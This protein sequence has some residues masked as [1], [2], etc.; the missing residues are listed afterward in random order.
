MNANGTRTLYNV[1]LL[2]GH[3]AQP[4]QIYQG[5]LGEQKEGKYT[6]TRGEAIKKARMFGGKIRPEENTFNT[7]V[8]SIE[9]VV[10]ASK[11]IH[12]KVCAGIN[13]FM[14][15]LCHKFT[16]R[17]LEEHFNLTRKDV[18]LLLKNSGENGTA[19]AQ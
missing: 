9:R 4:D 11:H 2:A 18:N 13:G 19:E 16:L 7:K 14:A 1:L 12:Y 17:E 8:H 5:F 3:T 6:Y 10:S 15:E